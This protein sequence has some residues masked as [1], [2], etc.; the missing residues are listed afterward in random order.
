M[1]FIPRV[2]C[3]ILYGSCFCLAFASAAN[4]QFLP[5]G[6]P[7]HWISYG[8]GSACQCSDGSLANM[9]GDS[10][11]CPQSQ[12]QVNE[13]QDRPIETMNCNNGTYCD[14]G[15][16]CIR[17][18]GCID[19]DH[20]KDCGDG[21]MCA[22]Y[23]VC[24]VKSKRC[25]S[26]KEAESERKSLQTGRLAQLRGSAILVMQNPLGPGAQG[27]VTQ[28]WSQPWEGDD[29]KLHTGVD[30]SAPRGAPVLATSAG[31][32]YQ[33]GW[34]G[35]RGDHSGH[36]RL[37]SCP[38]TEQNWGYYVVVKKDDGSASGY[39]HLALAPALKKNEVVQA[40]T[41]LGSV[42]SDHLHYNECRKVFTTSWSVD[43]CQK[44][45][46]LPQTF[47]QGNYLKPTIQK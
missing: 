35:C 33:T 39:L 4:A 9:V 37:S 29:T 41:L 46:V 22:S 11:V 12:P 34:L 31:S 7:G 6:C 25:L 32:V 18:T 13:G 20:A 23:Q 45:G 16:V 21:S 17:G 27:K 24:S 28:S 40:G 8:G 47:N 44:G 15:R 14:Q 38:G 5:P 2:F 3:L 43:G 10:I 36:L 30:V 26:A 19:R 42:Y 1:A